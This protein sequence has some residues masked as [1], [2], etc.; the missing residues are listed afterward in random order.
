MTLMACLAKNQLIKRHGF[1]PIQH[2]LG[3][4]IRLP[5]SVLAAPDELSAHSAAEH[6]STFHRRLAIRQAARMAWARLDNSSRVRRAMLSKSRAPRGPWLPG[7]QVYFWRRAGLTK[8]KTMKGRVRQDPDRWIG[9]GVVLAVEGT[10]AVWISYRAKLMKVAP[11]HVREATAEETFAQEFVLEE[12]AEQMMNVS[13]PSAQ[14]GFYDLTGQGGTPGAAATEPSE[15]PGDRVAAEPEPEGSAGTP[16]TTPP[17]E[18][19]QPTTEEQVDL[20]TVQFEAEPPLLPL[21]A[22]TIPLPEDHD[23]LTLQPKAKEGKGSKELNARTF[24][25]KERDLYDASDLKELTAWWEKQTYE[26]LTQQQTEKIVKSSPGRIIP[27]R[28][29]VVRTNTSDNKAEIV[30]KSRIVV[31]GHNDQ[32]L[33]QFRI[34]SPTAPQLALYFLRVLS[35]SFGWD[36]MS[37]DAWRRLS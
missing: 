25:K 35:A 9:P 18:A 5:A 7:T 12:L 6:D 22:A 33:G 29:C 30:A 2:V 24:D 17:R 15:H 3:Q 19:Q 8:K 37:F 26:E 34:D 10:R 1:S 11:E 13:A 31:P 21:D 20:P 16:G 23:V 28:A 4:D 32:D 36:L 27:G 14:T